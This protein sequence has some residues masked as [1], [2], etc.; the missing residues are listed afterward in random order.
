MRNIAI[1]FCC[2]LFSC[3]VQKQGL[4]K[5][6]QNFPGDVWVFNT[7][8]P[9][10]KGQ[11]Q[12]T[13][14]KISIRMPQGQGGQKLE[15]L[16]VQ[17]IGES[18]LNDIEYLEVFSSGSNPEM[19]GAILASSSKVA[20]KTLSL[21]CNI[22]LNAGENFLWL[23][24]KLSSTANVQHKL[25]VQVA[26][27]QI[28]QYGEIAIKSANVANSK[29]IGWALRR[30]N[31][32]QSHTYRI[33]G[34]V[35]TKQGSLIAVY[36]VR[37]E[38][39]RDLPANVDVAISRSKDGGQSWEP[40][41]IIMDM[42]PGANDGIGDPS[43]LVD[44][45]TGTIWVAALWSHGN[46]G[47]FGSAPGLSPDETGQFVLV[48]SEDDG[49]TWSAPINITTQIKNPAWRLF[50][51]GPGMGISM[52]DGTLVF[53]AQYKDAEAMPYSTLIYSKDHGKTWKVGIG[54]KSNTTEAQIVELNDGSLMLNMRDN[55][56]GSRSVATTRDLGQSWTEHPTSRSA[57]IEPVCMASIIRVASR[58]RGDTQDILAFSNPNDAK[59]RK[60]MTIKLSLDEGQSW[61]TQHQLLID[62]RKGYGYSCLTMIDKNTIGLIY[63]GIR[64]LYFV[65]VPLQ[66]IL[67]N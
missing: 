62:E 47:W 63:E 11:D 65:R 27:A 24:C 20:Q 36:D 49:Q 56:G 58:Q 16:Q 26:K 42:G 6:P 13:L 39:D 4:V 34:L 60:N 40:M 21:P 46:K 44:Q 28:G 55:R 53:P 37:Y 29:Y 61:P 7:Q 14:A 52:R 41:K 2:L 43:I 33:P 17:L 18:D 64:E 57:L 67:K 22:S 51:Q 31:Q 3:N 25:G 35:T 66:D 9:V 5:R 1:L 12:N 45:Q 54:A 8:N 48:K 38:N 10:L 15:A 50:F 19:E 32:D 59:E 30:R 23:S